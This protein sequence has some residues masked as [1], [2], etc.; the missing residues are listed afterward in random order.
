[1]VFDAKEDYFFFFFV[2]FLAAFLAMLWISF[3]G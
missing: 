3:F 1:M 2:F